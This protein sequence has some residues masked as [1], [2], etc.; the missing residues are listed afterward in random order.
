MLVA[1]WVEDG[2]GVVSS[3]KEESIHSDCALA[4]NRFF[5]DSV[6]PDSRSDLDT[7]FVD[8]EETGVRCCFTGVLW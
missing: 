4:N 1:G 3:F 8:D 6:D 5:L 7:V 2:P